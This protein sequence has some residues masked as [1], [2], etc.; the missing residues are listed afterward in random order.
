MTQFLFLNF[1]VSVCIYFKKYLWESCQ[2]V[3]L[4]IKHTCTYVISSFLHLSVLCWQARPSKGQARKPPRDVNNTDKD[5]VNN[6]EWTRANSNLEIA[7]SFWK[8][9]ECLWSKCHGNESWCIYLHLR[10]SQAPF[11]QSGWVWGLCICCAN[12]CSE[13]W[14]II[15]ES[16]ISK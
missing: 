9:S 8:N 5:L 2:Y 6:W 1:N 13:N 11:P 7:Q 14:E 15:M 16:T 3:V 4:K 12:I 10:A